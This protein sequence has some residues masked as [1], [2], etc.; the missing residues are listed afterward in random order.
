MRDKELVHAS[1]E[2]HR[3]GSA[4]GMCT[5]TVKLVLGNVWNAI[6]TLLYIVG[7]CLYMYDLKFAWHILYIPCHAV[8]FV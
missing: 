8:L 2:M 4:C 5:D 6:Y 1:L 3:V 7:M